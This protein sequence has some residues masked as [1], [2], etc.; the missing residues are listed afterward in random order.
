MNALPTQEAPSAGLDLRSAGRRV[1]LFVAGLVL[2]AVALRALPGLGDVRDRFG[3]ASLAWL[4]IAVACELGSVFSFPVALRGAFSRIMPWRPAFT[5]GLVEQGTNVLVPAGGTGGLA[6]GAVLLQRRGVP[7]AFAATR[8]VALFLATSLMTFLAIIASG[9][10]IALGADG[11]E[12]PRWVAALVA[13]GAA[14]AL[15]FAV[16]ISRL[17]AAALETRGRLTRILAKARDAVAGGVRATIALL[18]RGD[19]LLIAGSI[20]YL[21][22]DILALAAM[23]EALGGGAPPAA[24]FV[25]AYTLGQAGSLIPTPAGVGGTEGS[26]IGMFVLC[27]A[28]LSA[29]TAA[30][31][32]YRVAQLGVPALLGALA[33]LD[34]R[35]LIRTGPAPEEI[36]AR[37]ADD[38]RITELR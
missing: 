7:A 32:A 6:F 22:F 34:L 35:R 1:L 12:I 23:F 9:I 3:S 25:F 2:I 15:A 21:V 19:V 28:S 29:A 17:P 10:A 5:L 13:A 33:S 36:A 16:V 24:A 11:G 14:A 4:A 18:R 27:G 8:T 31:L 38:P 26:L 30:V 37:H 20:G